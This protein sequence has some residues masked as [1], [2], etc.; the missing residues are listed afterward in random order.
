MTD[1]P[2]FH[3]PDYANY[4]F[5]VVRAFYLEVWFE[6]TTR[7]LRVDVLKDL[8][9]NYDPY[10]VRIF[11]ASGDTGEFL[12]GEYPYWTGSTPEEAVRACFDGLREM[13][14]IARGLEAKA[15]RQGDD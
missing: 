8:V 15:V 5:E 14:G 13:A 2:T 4:A 10:S 6:E 12:D 7:W 11:G 1:K 9:G 3:I